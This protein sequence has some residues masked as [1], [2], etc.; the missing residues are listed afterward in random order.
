MIAQLKGKLSE[1]DRLKKTVNKNEFK[2]INNLLGTLNLVEL[3][4]Y[5]GSK[6]VHNQQFWVDLMRLCEFSFEDKWR[7]LYRASENGLGANDSHS[8][9][10][11]HSKTLT[12][13]KVDGSPYIFGGFSCVFWESGRERKEEPI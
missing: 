8:K 11:N 4:L 12:I 7:L 6:I 13:I 9:C 2:S 10:G 1:F 5:P 3:F